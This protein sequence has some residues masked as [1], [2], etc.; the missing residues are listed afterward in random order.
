MTLPMLGIRRKEAR[1][2]A[3]LAR[4]LAALDDDARR[5]R[6]AAKRVIRLSV[7]A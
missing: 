6:P 5:V 2:V 7:G 4:A 3:R 1:T